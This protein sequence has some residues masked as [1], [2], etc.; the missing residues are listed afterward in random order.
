[1]TNPCEIGLKCPYCFYDEYDGYCTYP[2]IVF[3]ADGE[4]YENVRDTDCPIVEPQSPL[5]AFLM[6]YEEC[7]GVTKYD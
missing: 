2:D 5:C 6:E 4:T 1:M 7:N 3:E